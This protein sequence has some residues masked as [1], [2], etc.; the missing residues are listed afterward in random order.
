MSAS[1]VA[2]A[3]TLRLRTN[4]AISFTVHHAFAA[5]SAVQLVQR[6]RLN[7]ALVVRMN[8]AATLSR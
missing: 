6:W 8:N 2:A 4:R 1:G 5:A 3:T 7:H